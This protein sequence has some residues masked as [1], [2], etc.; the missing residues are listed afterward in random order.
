VDRERVE[1][2]LFEK[3]LLERSSEGNGGDE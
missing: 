2:F 1:Q 3:G